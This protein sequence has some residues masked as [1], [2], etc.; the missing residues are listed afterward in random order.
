MKF[1]KVRINGKY[2]RK[3]TEDSPKKGGKA[4]VHYL[5]V[6]V[7][8]KN[9][10][11]REVFASIAGAPPVWYKPTKFGRWLASDPTKEPAFIEEAGKV[12]AKQLKKLKSKKL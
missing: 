6:Y 4:S 11:N 8:D 3:Q 7:L 2:F 5:P 9:P 10:L 1:E 12:T